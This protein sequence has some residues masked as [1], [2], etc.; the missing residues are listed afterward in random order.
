[1]ALIFCSFFKQ[2]NNIISMVFGSRRGASHVGLAQKSDLPSESYLGP[3]EFP[4]L[5]VCILHKVDN[6]LKYHKMC[7]ENSGSAKSTMS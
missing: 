6:G 3:N 5:N 4:L 7:G 1:M 2:I